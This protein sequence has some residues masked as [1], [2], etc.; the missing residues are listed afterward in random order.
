MG[1]VE[2]DVLIRGTVDEVIAATKDCLRKVSP[3]GRHIISSGNTITSDVQPENLTA[4]IETVHKFGRY[5][6]E[7]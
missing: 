4:M 2:V 5:P 1:N 7:L 6:I 3:G